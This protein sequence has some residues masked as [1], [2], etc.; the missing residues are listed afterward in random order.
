MATTIPTRSEPVQETI[1]GVKVADSLRWLENGDSAEVRSWTEQ[2]NRFLRQTLDAVA[3]RKRLVERLWAL[4]GI[5]T[6]EAPVPKARAGRLAI[7]TRGVKASRTSRCC[8]CDRG[9]P[10]PSRILL[11]VNTLAADGTQALDWWYPS[12]DGRL[13]AYGV[14]VGGDEKSTLRVRGRGHGQDRPDLIPWTRACSLAWLPSGRGFYYT[15][16]PAPGSV[17]AGQEEY[18]RR[19]FLAPSGYRPEPGSYDLR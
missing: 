4:L 14:S 3:S 13:L 5:G 15:R 19:V 18:Q 16:Y 1:H 2:Q 9:S 7:S 6:L 17:P 11:D 10:E 8:T 12:E